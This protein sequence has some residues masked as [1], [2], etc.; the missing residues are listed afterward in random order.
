[1]EEVLF[2]ALPVFLLL[3]IA[4]ILAFLYFLEAQRR[5]TLPVEDRIYR[6]LLR[7]LARFQIQRGVSEGPGTL[8]LRIEAERPKLSPQIL[9]ILSKI[10]AARFGRSK[11]S[12]K[13]AADLRRKIRQIKKVR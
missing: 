6:Q 3:G 11:L 5:E 7:V 12:A 9:P 13:E 10:T 2:R 8:M 1:M 4:L